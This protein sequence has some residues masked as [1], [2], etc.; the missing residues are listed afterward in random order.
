MRRKKGLNKYLLIP[1]WAFLFTALF[2]FPPFNS[3]AGRILY[4]EKDCLFCHSKPGISQLMSDGQLRSIYV[5]PEK[6]SEDVHSRSNITCV[7]CHLNANPYLHIREGFTDVN[8]SRCHPEEEE[9]YQKNIHLSFPSPSPGKKLPLCYDCH[10]KHHILRHDSARASI[11]E[12]NIGTTCGTCHAEVM[13]KALTRGSSLWKISGHRKGDLSEKFEMKVCIKCHYEDS[14]HGSK[15]PYGD[16][17]ARCHNYRQ[18]ADAILGPTHLDSK[19]WTALNYAGTS[20]ALALLLSTVI[21]AGYKSRDRISVW[22]KILWE[23]M[24]EEESSPQSQKPS[25]GKKSDE[26]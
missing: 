3:P 8:C 10:T 26:S 22:L 16:F 1:V 4:S 7:D 25:P 18:K 15:R 2:L 17:C 11:S 6:W 20:L 5:D 19:K 12:K 14:A 13:V 23:S 9:E 21:L 24:K